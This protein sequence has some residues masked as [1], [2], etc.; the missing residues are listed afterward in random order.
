MFI[1]L[2]PCRVSVGLLAPG[3]FSS[4]VFRNDLLT[5]LDSSGTQHSKGALRARNESVSQTVAVF[6]FFLMFDLSLFTFTFFPQLF[7]A[8]YFTFA[9]AIWWLT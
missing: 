9:L 4:A 3:R 6:P 7:S 5:L 1:L 2:T 8:A